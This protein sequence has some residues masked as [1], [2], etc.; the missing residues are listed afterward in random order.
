M[1]ITVASVVTAKIDTLAGCILKF[2]CKRQTVR[3]MPN[4]GL[5]G[6]GGPTD[7]MNRS[8]SEAYGLGQ[9]RLQANL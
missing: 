6:Q 4:R 7:N 9:A 5:H 3:H 2:H 1:M 8:G